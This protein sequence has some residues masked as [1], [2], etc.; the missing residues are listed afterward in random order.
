MV[1]A[2]G[3]VSALHFSPV[4]M[5]GALVV[6]LGLALTLFV[7]FIMRLR[8]A[9]HEVSRLRVENT[10]MKAQLR[11]LGA[12]KHRLESAL[13]AVSDGARAKV[14]FLATMSHELR[15]PLNAILGFS[16]MLAMEIYG[17]LG[18]PRYKDY[19][20]DVRGSGRHLLALVNDILDLSK[21]DAG[22]LELQDELIDVGDMLRAGLKMVEG[23]AK[24]ARIALSCDVALDLPHIHGDER[25][26][27]QV[28]INLLSNAVKFT[29]AQGSVRAEAQMCA[30]ELTIRVIDTGIGMA[31]KDIPVALER[32]GQVDNSLSRDNTGTGLGLPL[33]KKLIELHGGTLTLE[34]V[35]DVGTCVTV[36]LPPERLVAQEAS[37][38]P[39]E[40]VGSSA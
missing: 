16:E 28:F 25:R 6:Q 12:V 29:Q 35:V 15:T 24:A 8:A 7:R 20:N 18:D 17:P 37:D 11:D 22:K 32:F 38:S 40:R 10:E 36:R 31:A 13:G 39:L 14:Q 9:G 2:A 30:D 4:F 19:V 1:D 26:I 27:R 33:A 34:S 23:E 5:A 21:V 3:L